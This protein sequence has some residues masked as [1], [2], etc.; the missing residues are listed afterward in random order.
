MVIQN[1][2]DFGKLYDELGVLLKKGLKNLT[3]DEMDRSEVIMEEISMWV[4]SEEDGIEPEIEIL[5]EGYFHEALDR[6]YIAQ[7]Y[8][9]N[10]L[11]GHPV[12]SQTPALAE[13]IEKVQEILSELYQDIAHLLVEVE[14]NSKVL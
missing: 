11:V 6:T 4:Q 13:K 1:T 12:Y 9:E 3:P 5:D 14:D 7:D 8:I 10:T 2:E